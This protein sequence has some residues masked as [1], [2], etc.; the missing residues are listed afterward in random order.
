MVACYNLAENQ[1]VSA[2]DRGCL[3]RFQYYASTTT[4]QTLNNLSNSLCNHKTTVVYSNRF[5]INNCISIPS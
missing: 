5:L 4:E 1:I 3:Q 2:T